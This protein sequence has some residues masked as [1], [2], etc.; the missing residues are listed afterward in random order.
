[1]PTQCS[2]NR[3]GFGTVEGRAVVASFDGGAIT[4]NAGALLLGATDR[5][6]RLVE[7]FATCFRDA[8]T[9]ELIE[10]SVATLV[11]QR[12]F[13]LAL[14]YEDLIDHDQLRRDPMFAVLAGKLAA[15]RASCAPVAGK[16]TL[17]RLEHAPEG[18]P[19]RYHKIGHDG[20]AIEQLF[21]ELFLEAHARPPKQIVLD[22]D[23]TDVPLHGHQEGRFFHGYYDAYCYLP[24]YVFCG[25]H[26]L[27]AKLRRSNIDG[28]AGAV[29][30][31]ERLVRHIRS[32][33]PRVRILLRADSG[34]ARE[35]LMSWCERNRVDYLFG[36]ARNKRLEEEISIEMAWAEEDSRATGQR[37]RRFKDV[38]WTTRESWSRR[39]RVIGK[40]EWTQGEGNPR[41]IV[42]S[43]K[44]EEVGARE[45]YERIY[46]ARGEA[47]TR[48][49]QRS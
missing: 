17:N 46:C 27:A 1:M 34:F 14:G 20:A 33:W 36:L 24:L 25:R 2:A 41:F 13:A 49:V 21:V 38:Q 37:A 15:R 8:R 19:S 12:V 6:I 40:A 5:A 18:A 22:L 28:S 9:P 39:R 45:L 42:T 44:P 10:H 3:F 47:E 11:G 4:S 16:S 29:E 26:L 35:G 7:R 31:V 43:L 30:E 23:T 48:S 32:R